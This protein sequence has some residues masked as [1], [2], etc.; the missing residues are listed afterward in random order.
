MLVGVV[1]IDLDE[2]LEDGGFAAGAFDGKACAVVEVTEDV[3]VVLVVAILRPKNGRADG[4]SEVFNVELSA[5]CCDVAASKSTAALCADEIESSEVVCLA[6]G[7]ETPCA[8]RVDHV[9]GCGEK[10]GSDDLVTVVAPEA[11]EMVDAAKS[12]DK[13]TGHDFAAGLTRL[14]PS[15]GSAGPRTSAG[16]CC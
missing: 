2:L 3:S 11:V 9:V 7:E 8:G 16:A 15:S 6:K 4:A 13:L 5:E 14:I 12:S 10:L 1:A